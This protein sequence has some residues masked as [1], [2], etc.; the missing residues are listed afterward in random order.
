MGWLKTTGKLLAGT[1]YLAGKA[2]VATAKV[3]GH[4]LHGSAKF[5]GDHRQE[6]A[7]ATK[8]VVNVTGKLVEGTGAAIASGASAA[9]RLPHERAHY[10][11]TSAAA[12]LAVGPSRG[13][14]TDRITDFPPFDPQNDQGLS[15]C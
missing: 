7:G 12:R 1:A 5:V 2:T 4:A 8:A 11:V 14:F 13:R 9:S 6:I 15:G 3:T 10:G